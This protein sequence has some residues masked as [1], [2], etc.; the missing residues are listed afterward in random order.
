MEHG[1]TLEAIAWGSGGRAIGICENTYS[2][3]PSTIA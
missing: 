3:V 2:G 1:P